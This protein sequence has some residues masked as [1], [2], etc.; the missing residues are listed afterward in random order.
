MVKRGETKTREFQRISQ[1]MRTLPTLQVDDPGF[2][3]IKYLRYADDWIVGIWGS[4]TLAE[5]VKQEIKTF[6]SDQLQLTLGEEKT[7]ITHARTEEALFLGTRLKLGA[8]AEA[9]LTLQTNMWGKKFKRR[10]TGWETVMTAPLPKMLKRLS[11]RGFCTK[12]GKPIAKSGWAFLDTD[13]IIL[14]YSSVN[15]GTQNYYRFVDNWVQLQRIQYIL[16]YSLAMT[17]GRKFKI[18][19]RHPSLNALG[20]PSLTSSETKREKRKRQ[21]PSISITIGP[22]TGMLFKTRSMPILTSSNQRCI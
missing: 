7:H 14:L 18:S 9:K 22:R 6:L 20:R 12:E 19:T 1:Q 5:Q 15:R 11:D 10:S 2:I 4:H 16:Q 8:G 3:R 13:Q 21:S 17:L